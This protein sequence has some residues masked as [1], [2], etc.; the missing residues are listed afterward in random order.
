MYHQ[1]AEPL[2]NTT[3]ANCYFEKPFHG[4]VST[5]E[6]FQARPVLHDRD[7]EEILGVFSGERRRVILRSPHSHRIE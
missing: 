3:V 2:E 4:S 7:Y 1:M 5:K 6:C